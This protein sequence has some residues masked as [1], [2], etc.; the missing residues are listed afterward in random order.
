MSGA[1][2]GNGVSTHSALWSLSA[3]QSGAAAVA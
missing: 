2:S 1:F 3:R